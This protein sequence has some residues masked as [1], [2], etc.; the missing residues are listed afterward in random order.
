LV[1]C[2]E[3]TDLPAGVRVQDVIIPRGIDLKP[4]FDG[5]LLG[6]ATVL[7]GRAEACREPEWTGTLYRE[8]ASTPPKPFDLRLIPYF[9]WGNRG[10]S[11]MCVWMPLARS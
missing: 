11:E 1:Y 2:V 10:R 3:S 6:G 5:R 8:L 4:R 7:E 9:A